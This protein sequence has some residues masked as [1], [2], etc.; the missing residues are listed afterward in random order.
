MRKIVLGRTNIEVS[1]ISL[2]TWAFGG[3]NMSG[4]IAVGWAGQNHNDSRAVLKRA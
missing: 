1:A 2:G 3:A 4:K